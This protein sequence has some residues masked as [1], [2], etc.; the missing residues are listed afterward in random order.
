MRITQ[1]GLVFC[2]P[3]PLRIPIPPECC[4]I[5]PYMGE[6]PPAVVSGFAFLR[7]ALSEFFTW[8]PNFPGRLSGIG[9]DP[10]T[11]ALLLFRP[12][13]NN[14]PLYTPLLMKAHYRRRTLL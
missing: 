1:S 11:S 9:C 10:S 6:A 13:C 4:E 8:R 3:G 5:D 14:P 7:L 2:L 12:D